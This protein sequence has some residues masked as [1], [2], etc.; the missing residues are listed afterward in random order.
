[1]YIVDDLDKV[2]RLKDVPQSDIGA[3]LPIVIANE[4]YLGLLYYLSQPDPNWD[5]TYVNVVSTA[6]DEM[7]VAIIEFEL[8]TTH[9]LGPPNDEAFS[10]HPLAFR[11][12]RP[13]AAFEI[14]DSSWIRQLERM[15]SVHR[16]HDRTRF[17][18]DKRHFVFAF[19]N[20]LFECVARSNRIDLTRG[21]LLKAA[22]YTVER[23]RD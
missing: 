8:P 16:C 13:Y 15:N 14:L 7:A 22:A 10:G 2:K 12:L 6:S 20:S 17:M 3:P 9:S 19:H 11:G 4:G 18:S 5:G 1:L 23:L 21:S